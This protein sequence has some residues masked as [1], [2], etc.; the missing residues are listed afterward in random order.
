[1]RPEISV[2]SNKQLCE[3]F[4]HLLATIFEGHLAYKLALIAKRSTILLAPPIFHDQI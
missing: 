4:Y 2:I 3:V 1:L